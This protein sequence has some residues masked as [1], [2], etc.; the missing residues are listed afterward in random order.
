MVVLV[1]QAPKQEPHWIKLSLCGLVIPL[2][3]SIAPPF[4]ATIS[5]D[6]ST[7][8]VFLFRSNFLAFESFFI[9]LYFK[10]TKSYA[11]HCPVTGL[12]YYAGAGNV[13]YPCK[14]LILWYSYAAKALPW[15]V[16]SLFAFP[17]AMASKPAWHRPSN[18]YYCISALKLIFFLNCDKI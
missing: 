4:T 15:A 12:A 6:L 2:N 9:V 16:R 8:T 10:L 17:V 5:L 1:A 3:V 14:K 7:D 13:I 18:T 11:Q